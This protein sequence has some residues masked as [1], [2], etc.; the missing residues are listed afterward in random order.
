VRLVGNPAREGKDCEGSEAAPEELPLRG[1]PRREPESCDQSA[2]HEAGDERSHERDHAHGAVGLRRDHETANRCRQQRRRHDTNPGVSIERILA[3]LAR[4]A[5]VGVNEVE[6]FELILAE[7]A[8]ELA[9]RLHVVARA[10]PPVG[11]VSDRSKV[12]QGG[13]VGH[14]NPVEVEGPPQHHRDDSR[15]RHPDRPADKVTPVHL[16]SE[17]SI[18]RRACCEGLPRD[19]PYPE[20]CSS[21]RINGGNKC[22]QLLHPVKKDEQP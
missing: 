15:S 7:P 3:D 10:D 8:L 2:K 6:L 18:R 1:E 14:D 22:A 4:R 16:T 12:A 21:E 17:V 11:G 5:A 20:R 13:V 9:R 19:V